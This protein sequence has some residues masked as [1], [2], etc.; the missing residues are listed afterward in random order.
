MVGF[1]AGL[2]RS[3][4][5]FPALAET[6]GLGAEVNRLREELLDSDA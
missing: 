2:R 5:S 3:Y 6:L 1:L 4:G